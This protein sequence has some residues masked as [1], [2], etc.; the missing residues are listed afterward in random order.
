[1]IERGRKMLGRCAVADADVPAPGENATDFSV[2]F[3]LKY[4]QDRGANGD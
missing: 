2:L 4:A 1:M 3:D